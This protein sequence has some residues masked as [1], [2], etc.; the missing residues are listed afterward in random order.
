MLFGRGARNCLQR[1]QQIYCS[2]TQQIF[3]LPCFSFS[4]Q[5]QR[6]EMKKEDHNK[7]TNKL[8]LRRWGNGPWAPRSM[9]CFAIFLAPKSQ[10]PV[11]SV[12]SVRIQLDRGP[13]NPR[14]PRFLWLIVR[15]FISSPHRNNRLFFY[16]KFCFFTEVLIRLVK[17]K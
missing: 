15:S 1:R 8:Y 11:W 13:P 9:T 7:Q 2:R 17:N 14:P 4:T 12:V 6:R 10:P 5:Q 3:F 16:L